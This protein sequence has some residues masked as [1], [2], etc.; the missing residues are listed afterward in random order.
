MSFTAAYLT[1]HGQGGTR[2]PSDYVPESSR[3]ARGFATWAALRELG[4][5]GVADMIE[6]CCM[7]A[8]RFA[9][10]LDAL[11]GVTVVNDVVLNQVLVSFGDDKHTDRVVD[12]VQRSGECW[13]GATTWHGQRLMRISVSN[14]Q[15]A[16]PDVDR[17][18]AA[19][20]AAV[21]QLRG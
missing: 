19:I 21:S 6:R 9:E 10:Q 18:V 7:L 3:R 13:M 16:E 12:V 5:S 17:S 20:R 8:R 2:A 11:H 4:R 1:G 14:W 15:T